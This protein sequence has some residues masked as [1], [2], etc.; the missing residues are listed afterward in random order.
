MN[1][2]MNEPKA[3]YLVY[4]SCRHPVTAFCTDYVE[5]FEG[6]YD[7]EIAYAALSTR[8]DVYLA[9]LSKALRTLGVFDVAPSS[10]GAKT[11]TTNYDILDR[12]NAF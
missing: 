4:H 8:K 2:L 12:S 6:R 3:I 10:E 5:A 9:S 1:P 11:M 7:A